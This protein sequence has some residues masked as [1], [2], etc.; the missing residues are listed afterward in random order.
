MIINGINRALTSTLSIV[1]KNKISEV[2]AGRIFE[3]HGKVRTRDYIMK[4]ARTLHQNISLIS[5]LRKHPQKKLEEF[6]Q[7]RIQEQVLQT[8]PKE[9][10]SLGNEELESAKREILDREDKKLDIFDQLCN[11]ANYNGGSIKNTSFLM[12]YPISSNFSDTSSFISHFYL[13]FTTSSLS[14]LRLK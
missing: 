8:R 7:K 10:S 5:L 11:F 9:K 4:I 3:L 1:Y 2:I 12:E 6:L 14:K 13:L